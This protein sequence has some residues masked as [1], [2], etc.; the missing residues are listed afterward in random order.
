MAAELIRSPTAK[1]WYRILLIALLAAFTF[2]YVA[3][4]LSRKVEG[5]VTTFF[6]SWILGPALLGTVGLI[7]LTLTFRLARAEL[8]HIRQILRF[9]P[10]PVA[11]II[12]LATAPLL[13]PIDDGTLAT[14]PH[15]TLTNAG[16]CVHL[17]CNGASVHG[18]QTFHRTDL[19]HVRTQAGRDIFSPIRRKIEGVD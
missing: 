2:A 13:P 19:E 8:M 14:L 9:P 4:T 15:F 17:H 5:S 3:P 6:G 11:V 10:L 7:L 16:G 1:R 12:G 18:V